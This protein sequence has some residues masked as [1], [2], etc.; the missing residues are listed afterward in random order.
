MIAQLDSEHVVLVGDAGQAI[1]VAPKDEVHGRDTPLHLAFSCYVF[2]AEGRVLLTRRADD[3]L[4]WPGVWTNSCCGHPQPSEPIARAVARRLRHELGLAASRI[5]LML[6]RFRY[7]AVMA[8]GIVE[9]EVCPVYRAIVETDPQAN[10]EEVGAVRWMSWAGFAE[11]VLSGDLEISPWC[12]EQ[13]P[14]LVA[15]G[16]DPLRW[17]SADVALLPPAAIP[18]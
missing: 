11:G 4:T 10:P 3:K 8:S 18:D 12:R 9:Y 17:P 7:R 6:P 15:I 13:V 16:D 2:D 1:G 5:D 14:E